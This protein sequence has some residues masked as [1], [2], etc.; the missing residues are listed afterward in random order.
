MVLH[1]SAWNKVSLFCGHP[2]PLTS[3]F[4]INNKSCQKEVILDLLH[5]TDF[6]LSN[7]NLSQ[8]ILRIPEFG[9]FDVFQDLELQ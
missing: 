8:N 1:K 9:C 6:E 2:N 3:L 7:Y 4:C 5:S